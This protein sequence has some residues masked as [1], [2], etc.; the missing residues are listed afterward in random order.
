MVRQIVRALVPALLLA[1]LTVA[2]NGQALTD[3]SAASLAGNPLFAGLTLSDSERTAIASVRG[4]YAGQARLQLDSLRVAMSSAQA[5][6]GPDSAVVAARALARAA[7][8]RAHL[9]NLLSAER[10]AIR[11]L[12]TSAQQPSYDANVAADAA[13]ATGADQ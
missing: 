1:G 7:A 2:A 4:R 9:A 11:G 5:A 13:L 3:T 8:Y 10:S 12:L 6:Q